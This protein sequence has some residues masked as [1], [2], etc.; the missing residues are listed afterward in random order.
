MFLDSLNEI[1]IFQFRSI[2]NNIIVYHKVTR[3]SKDN[4]TDPIALNNVIICSRIKLICN[5][6]PW[7]YVIIR[8]K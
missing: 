3:I 6:I 5:I 1:I 7:N 2:R 4:K 8:A